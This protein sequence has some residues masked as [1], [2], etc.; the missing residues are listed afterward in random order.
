MEKILTS[1]TVGSVTETFGYDEGSATI[2]VRRS[3]DATP[4]LDHVA[5]ANIEGVDDVGG[6]LR[7]HSDVPITV[8]I[9]FCE[10]R[11]IPWEKFCYTTHY[12]R[13]W[14]AFIAANPRFLYRPARR[15]HAVTG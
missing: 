15:Q 4:V 1:D 10:E 8:A 5:A 14:F 11:G 2:V 12:D 13:E 7:L 3:Q 6:A 9:A